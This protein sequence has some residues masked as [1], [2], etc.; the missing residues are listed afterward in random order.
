MKGGLLLNLESTANVMSK[1]G[2]TELALGK[3]YNAEET[4]AKLMAVT[5]E[6]IQRTINKLIVPDKLVLAQVG[7][8]QANINLK[9][10]L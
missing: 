5:E 3:I 7:P 2:R 6:D 1:L 8:Q 9:E 4:A 10:L